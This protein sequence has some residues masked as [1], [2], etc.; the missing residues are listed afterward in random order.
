MTP[1]PTGHLGRLRRVGTRVAAALVVWAVLCVRP[2]PTH[3]QPQ[4]YA[5]AGPSP[6]TVSDS[7]MSPERAA[8]RAER[9][10]QKRRA[11]R[12]DMH[13][14]E[15]GFLEQVGAF[16]SNIRGSVVPRR[17][18]LTPPQLDASG[19]SL[20]VRELGE[21]AGGLLYK[22]PPLNEADQL[23]SL[24]GTAGIG[25]QYATEGLF[26]FESER[27][28][29]YAY[30]R[31]RHSPEERFYGLGP[32]SRRSTTSSF[33]RDEGLFGGLF[34]VSLAPETLI[35]GHVSYQLNRIGT[36]Y[37]DLSDGQRPGRMLPGADENVDFLMMGSFFEYDS[38]DTPYKRAFG[39]RFAPTENRLRGVSVDATRGYYLAAEATH[40]LDYRHNDF[41]F[42]RFTL[43]MREFIPIN[44]ELLHGFAVRQLASVTRSSSGQMPFYRMTSLGGSR[45]LRGFGADRFR[46]RNV[47]L[48][49]AEVRCEI[50]HRLDMALFTDAGHVFRE[51]SGLNVLTPR[52]GYGVGF[53]IKKNGQT[54]GRLDIAH[55]TEGLRTTINVGSLF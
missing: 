31:Y 2:A 11:K 46:D 25:G 45:S 50:W 20:L 18:I 52:V 16:V 35:G 8:H 51:V 30:G 7:T 27:Y 44:E 48:V 49:N 5:D 21:P 9:W 6:R 34:G 4:P 13:P 22:P 12:E 36:V 42:T 3:A 29:G 1:V 41:S 19:L 55:S 53:R 54:L 17:L 10:K 32:N 39:H 37:G 14:P 38:R 28:V 33:R 47:A 24:Q 43:D 23:T 15:P 40:N 26:G